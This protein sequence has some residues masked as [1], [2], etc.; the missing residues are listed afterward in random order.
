MNI[1]DNTTIDG[2]NL[3]ENYLAFSPSYLYLKFK[4]FIDKVLV[5]VYAYSTINEILLLAGAAA[6]NW[7]ANK[8]SLLYMCEEMVKKMSGG[9][10]T[11]RK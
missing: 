5:P 9:E 4:I 1:Y 2:Q 10:V 7:A 11:V 3:L 8:N 6:H